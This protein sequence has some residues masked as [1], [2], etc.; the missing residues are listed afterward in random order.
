VYGKST[1]KN[2]PII[3]FIYPVDQSDPT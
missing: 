3:I 1:S 2:M